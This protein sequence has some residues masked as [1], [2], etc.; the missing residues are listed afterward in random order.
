MS[1]FNN[2]M[3][4]ITTNEAPSSASTSAAASSQQAV[5]VDASV[6]EK[7]LLIE[8]QLNKLTSMSTAPGGP[9]GPGGRA[10]IMMSTRALTPTNGEDTSPVNSPVL[11]S[12]KVKEVPTTSGLSP[13]MELLLQSISEMNGNLVS[14]SSRL[15]KLERT[16]ESIGTSRSLES[17]PFHQEPAVSSPIRLESPTN[18]V[19]SRKGLGR[20][21]RVVATPEVAVQ[22][23]F[24]KQ[25]VTVQGPSKELLKNLLS[26]ATP[27]KVN[28]SFDGGD[29]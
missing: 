25:A 8:R 21:K 2:N 1:N 10:S 6:T 4:I 27:A 26:P 16:T 15:D 14:V 9:G 7:L 12:K 13:D 17:L 5:G 24:L 29:K 22:S 23:G 18:I 3:K 20:E 28:I 11:V 19:V